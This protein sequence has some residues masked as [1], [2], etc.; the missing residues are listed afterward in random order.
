MNLGLYAIGIGAALVTMVWARWRGPRIERLR[1]GTV[2]VVMQAIY[3]G[4]VVWGILAGGASLRGLGLEL[5][6]LAL[7]WLFAWAA[8]RGQALFLPLGYLAHGSWDLFHE[9]AGTGYV[10][11]GYP[12]LCVA[13][14]WFLMLYFLT[15]LRVWRAG[16]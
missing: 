1:W 15:R 7:C 13:Y 5:A 2:L 14:D 9:L 16:S 12:D 8:W 4:F 6:L 3:V 11:D 10:I